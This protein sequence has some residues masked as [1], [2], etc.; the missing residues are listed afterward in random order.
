MHTHTHIYIL[1]KMGR[2]TQRAKK[3]LNTHTQ[4]WTNTDGQETHT[5]DRGTDT[6]R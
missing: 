2:Y 6:Q 5:D 3:R 4:R 1:Y